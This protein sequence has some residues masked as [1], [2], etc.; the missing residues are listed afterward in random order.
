VWVLPS[1]PLII[2][3]SRRFN[4][5][6]NTDFRPFML[7]IDR[8]NYTEPDYTDILFKKVCRERHHHIL[9]NLRN[10][11]LKYQNQ[12]KF[13]INWITDLAHDDVRNYKFKS[14]C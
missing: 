5:I 14:I 4:P 11:L 1:R 13:S 9:K 7:R 6:F 2:F 12:P 3:W 8:K 10:F